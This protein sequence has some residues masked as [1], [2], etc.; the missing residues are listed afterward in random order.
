MHQTAARWLRSAGI[1]V[2]TGLLLLLCAVA[3]PSAL[4]R[5]SL[6]VIWPFAGIL[7][8]AALGQTLVIQQRGIDLSIPGFISLAGIVVSHGPNGDSSKLFEFILL[9]YLFGIIGGVVNGFMVTRV[10][11][12]A[13]VQTLGM[14]AALYG[15][16]IAICHGT[17]TE[18]TSAMQNF[19]SSSVL[20][21]PTPFF[22]ALVLVVVIEIVIKKTPFGRRF[23]AGGVSDR[24][25]R[26]AGIRVDSYQFAA[27]VG[28]AILYTTAGI[29]LAGMILQPDPFAGDV[30]LLASVAAVVL[31]SAVASA[32]GAF[33]LIVLQQFILA[34]GASAGLQDVV[35]ALALA[36]GLGIY[37]LRQ[38]GG[39]LNSIKSRFAG[40]S[41]PTPVLAGS[42]AVP[43]ADEIESG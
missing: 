7:M 16:D 40:K 34:T 42:L 4:G 37:G 36:V 1:V 17:P 38:K 23:E 3:E 13:I 20:G 15:V 35:E 43:P 21:V 29:L 6:S 32:V 41:P 5:A 26:S 24:A 33:F 28:S 30:Y 31:G 27:Y 25:G 2:A 14:N 12:P 10:G 8:I 19:A 9:A 22:I 39:A 11:M 18:T